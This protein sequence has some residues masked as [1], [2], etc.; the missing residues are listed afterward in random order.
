[1]QEQQP[2]ADFTGEPPSLE[3]YRFEEKAYN[4]DRDRERMRGQLAVA[5][6]VT[7]GV[8]LIGA[9]IFIWAGKLPPSTFPQLLTPLVALVGSGLG[10]YFGGQHTNRSG[11]V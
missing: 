6:T 8:I 1:M 2:R 4:P 3:P 11:G 7:F 10:F 9:M 5:L